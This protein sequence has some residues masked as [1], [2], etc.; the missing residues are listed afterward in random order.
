LKFPIL[1]PDHLTGLT[2]ATTAYIGTLNANYYTT[3]IG[4][5]EHGRQNRVQDGAGTIYRTV[6][7]GL[8]RP[9][10]EWVGDDDTP[11]SG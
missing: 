7:D 6:Y 4:Y 1:L 2:Y 11:T 3:T 10:S 9:V 8:G 5:D